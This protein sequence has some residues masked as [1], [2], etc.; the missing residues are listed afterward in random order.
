MMY[1]K[2][3]NT[4]GV[5]EEALKKT[6]FNGLKSIGERSKVLL[7]PPDITQVDT[8]EGVLT[9]WAVEYYQDAVKAI[10]P[11]TG[12]RPPMT[13]SELNQY[14]PGLDHSLFVSHNYQEDIVT[15]ETIPASVI[16]EMSEGRLSFNWKAQVNQLLVS[17]GFDLILSIGEVI[18]DEITGMSNYT[19]NIFMGT[20]GFESIHKCHYLSAIYGYERIIGQLNS[21]VRSLFQYSVEQLT[22]PLPIVYVLTVTDYTKGEETLTPMGLFMGEEKACFEE[23]AQLSAKVHTTVLETPQNTIVVLLDDKRYRSLWESNKTLYRTSL[24]LEDKGELIIIAPNLKEASNDKDI[25]RLI[26]KY[27]YR[28]TEDTVAA[29]AE[30]DDLKENLSVAAHLI[31][32]STNNRFTV[33]YACPKEMK[34]TVEQ[35]GYHYMDL[36]KATEKY[37]TD[38][39]VDGINTTDDG[40]TFYYISHIAKGVWTHANRTNTK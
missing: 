23:A 35:V 22:T 3:R 34:S 9:L 14:F 39:V 2:V 20:S 33:T 8:L 15:L 4:H 31:N 11:A 27:G 32:G 30:H 24:A 36:H 25:N 26:K 16:Q 18:P 7:I 10:L 12:T 28:G 13:S 6:F 1:A 19:K 21:P 37:T 17:G 38:S 40:E 5:S 29:V